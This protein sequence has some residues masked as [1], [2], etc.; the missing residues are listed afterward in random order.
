MIITLIACLSVC[1][2]AGL[3]TYYWLD[4]HERKKNDKMGLAPTYI[5]LNLETDLDYNLNTKRSKIRIFHIYLLLCALAERRSVLLFALVCH[6][7]VFLLF[8]F[9]ELLSSKEI[10][11]EILSCF[12]NA[13]F[14]RI[15]DSSY[16]LGCGRDFKSAV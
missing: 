6:C 8:N 1:L 15:F 5:L 14:S 7:I 10:C 9:V 11:G 4:L 12:L 3:Q 2:L 16:V 13:F